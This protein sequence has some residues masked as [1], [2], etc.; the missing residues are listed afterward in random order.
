MKNLNFT[1]LFIA[2]LFSA[3]LTQAQ[4]KVWGGP[5][6][7]SWG[8]ATHW[9]PVGVPGSANDVIIPPDTWITIDVTAFMGNLSVLEGAIVDKTTDLAMSMS[10]GNFAFTSIFNFD[11]GNVNTGNTNGGLFL[12]NS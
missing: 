10:G 9:S 12:Q 7:G 3:L 11:A 8:E 5:S 1:F 2:V 4:D 6:A